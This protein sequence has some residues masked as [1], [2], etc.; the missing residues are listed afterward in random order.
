VAPV[1]RGAHKGVKNLVIIQ[2]T[3][4]GTK[5]QKKIFPLVFSLSQLKTESHF[6]Q[7]V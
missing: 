6:I 4:N 2:C 5:I 7:S 1:K 3:K